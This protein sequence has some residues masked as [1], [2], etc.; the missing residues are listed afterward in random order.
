MYSVLVCGAFALILALGGWSLDFYHWGWSIPIAF[1]LFAG[2]WILLAR[3]LSSRMQPAMVRM[4]KQLEA[5]MIEPAM[6]SLE[7]L[8]PMARWVPMLRGQLLGQMGMLAYHNGDKDRAIELLEGSSMRAADARLMLAC[9]HHRNENVQRAFEVLALTS[10]VARK[11]PL[12][13]NTY[14]W[15]LQKAG[16]SDEA[17][18]VL[19]AFLRKN[20]DNKPTQ[21]NL[22][23][24]Q[25]KQR[26]SMAA[27]D[28][29]W[30]A[31][32]LEQPPQTMGQMRRA[33]KGFREA[34]KKK[35]GSKRR[36]G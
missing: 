13:H 28:M 3:S 14:A 26:M 17:Q 8:L 23:R 16:R 2:S 31:L 10:K 12:L 21:E 34:P 24:L 6:Q 33:R 25:N 36:R 4:Q 9:I 32:G 11:H 15:M 27:F 1:V 22:L 5:G 29:Q 19:A 7:A 20:A 18:V 35:A 30:Y